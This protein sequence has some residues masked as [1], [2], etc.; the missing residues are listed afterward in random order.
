M[1]PARF[2]VGQKQKAAARDDAFAFPQ[3]SG[4]ASGPSLDRAPP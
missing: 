2:L 3:S 1:I 4:F